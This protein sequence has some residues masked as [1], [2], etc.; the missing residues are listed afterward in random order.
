MACYHHVDRTGG[1]AIAKGGS[2]DTA[3]EWAL[4]WNE[5]IQFGITLL[6]NYESISGVLGKMFC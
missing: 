1:S 5:R 3:A 2:V 6:M 4:D